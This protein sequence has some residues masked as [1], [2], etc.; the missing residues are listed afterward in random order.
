MPSVKRVIKRLTV[1]SLLFFFTFGV[2]CA[3][4]GAPDLSV[5]WGQS[6][7]SG[8]SSSLGQAECEYP[9]FIC[10]SGSLFSL[11]ANSALA[12]IRTD[13]FSRETYSTT[14]SVF[15]TW[16]Y[17]DFSSPGARLRHATLFNPAPKISLHL[18]NSVLTC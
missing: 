2:W 9:G 18:F 12:S 6:G 15:D 7:C 1:F 11:A 3:I 10:A 4:L 8:N 5:A 16:P 14:I 17:S 13:G